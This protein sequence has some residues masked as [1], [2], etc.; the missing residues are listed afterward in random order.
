M[1]KKRRL[2]SLFIGLTVFATSVVSAFMPVNS[3]MTV[4]AATARQVE[5]L[6]RGLTAISTNNGVYLSWRYLGTDSSAVGFNIYRDGVKVNDSLI[7]SSTNYQ[8]TAGS[9]ASNYYVEA[10]ADGNVADTSDTVSV[11]GNN[12]FDIPLSIPAG[13]TTPSGDSYTYTANDA[14]CADLDGDGEYEIILKWMPTNAGDNMADG[15]RGNVYIDAYKLDG[16]QLWRVDLG[17]N[18]RAG[19]HYTPF[20]VYDFDGDGYGEMVCKTSDATVDGVGNVIGDANADY[21]DSAGTVLTGS[22]YLT[23]FDGMTGQALDTIDYEPARGNVKDWGD[24]YGNRSERYLAG[25]AYLNGQTPSVVMCR[26]Y[27]TRVVLASYDVVNK[28]LVKRWIFDSNDSGNS[29][30]AGQGNHNLAVGDV[31]NDGYDEIVYGA[32]TIDH[33]GKGLYSYGAG[34]GDAIH[35][36]DF[37]PTKAGLEIWS[38]FETS[39]YGAALRRASDGHVYFRWTAG[40]DTGRGLAANLIDGNG[41]YEFGASCTD[42]IVNSDNKAVGTWSGITKWGQNFR[43]YW[44]GDLADEVMDRTMIDGYGK[45]RILT[46]S[47]VSYNNGTKGNCSLAADILGDWREEVIWPVYDQSALRV[48]MT[49]HTTSYRIPTL[50]H[51]T[52][53]RCQVAAQNVGYNQPAHTSYYLDSAYSLPGQPNVYEAKPVSYEGTYYLKNANSNLYLD[54][55]NG[56][57]ED[58]ANIQQHRYNGYDAQKFKIVS[59]GNGYYHILTGAS[60]YNSCIDIASASAKNGANVLQWT[61]KG[62]SNQQFKLVPNDDGSFAILTRVSNCN[63]ALDVYDGSTASGGNVNQWSYWGGS[64]QHWYLEPVIE[65]TYYMQNAYSGLYLD[66]VNG[67]ADNGTNIQQHRFNGSDAQ[68]FKVVS[69]G[70]GYYYILT[71]AS[72]YN[73]CVDISGASA[74]NGANVLQWAY[75]GSGNQMYKIVPNADGTF[76]ILTK[77]SGDVAALEVYDWS[78]ASGG[79]VAQY[80]YWGGSLQHWKFIPAE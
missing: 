11:Y 34:H 76:A 31:D 69:N 16:T 72:G 4:Q 36:G 28:K 14:S 49:T 8:D 71:G 17:R 74:D 67:L 47:G 63:S 25:V 27:Y 19:Q 51:D 43:I 42:D 57:A 75:K 24:N 22:E 40:G 3:T 55:V 73:S 13:G 6:D 35:L 64:M 79:N 9:S 45:G 78:T 53:Y 37:D 26:G 61:Y 2:Q 50:M 56:S 80:E 52:Q 39:P 23:L 66:V 54:V 38:P 21:R 58:G 5:A 15:Y 30:Y 18:I 32:C 44:D 59:N 48:F 33:N 77:A 70:D 20:M 29:A 68:K 7:T 12:Y 10:V 46:A 1:H 62:S 60:G 65:G 41:S